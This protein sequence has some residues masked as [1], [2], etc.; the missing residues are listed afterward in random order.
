MS[1]LENIQI[2]TEIYKS[3]TILDGGRSRVE[4]DSMGQL[5][6]PAERLWGAQTQRSLIHFSIGNDRMPIEVHH[7]YGYVKKAAAVVK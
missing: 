5:K 2:S 6:V 7:A 3:G 4:F 1:Q